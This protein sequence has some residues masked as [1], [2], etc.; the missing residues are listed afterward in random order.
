MKRYRSVSPP[1][2]KIQLQPRSPIKIKSSRQNRFKRKSLKKVKKKY[3]Q[4][5]KISNYKIEDSN[6]DYE[7]SDSEISET[8]EKL[9]IKRQ[10]GRK[11]FFFIITF[12]VL[13]T[14]YNKICNLFV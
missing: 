5:K 12:I 4:Y 9:E 6:S 2:R 11:M 10:N 8:E 1:R 7:L 3:N 14:I 13:N